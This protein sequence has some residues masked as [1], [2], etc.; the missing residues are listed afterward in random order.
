MMTRGIRQA[1]EQFAEK[2][3]RRL[4]VASALHQN[5]QDILVLIHRPPEVMA[6]AMD[7]KKNLIQMPFGPRL[8]A[9]PPPIGVLL[10]KLP[11]PWTD[12]FMGHGDAACK[13]ELF[14]VAVTPREAIGE[15]DPTADDFSGKPVVFVTLGISV[16]GHV[17]LPILVCNGS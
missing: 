11:T 9:P 4:F 17:A 6:F 14:H 10:P 15:P 13:Q 1:F 7:R 3:L 2:L 5:I 16:R 12:G 8:W